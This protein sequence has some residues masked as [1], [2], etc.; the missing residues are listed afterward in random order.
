MMKSNSIHRYAAALLIIGLASF[1]PPEIHAQDNSAVSEKLVLSEQIKQA[2]KSL[3]SAS[4][5]KD[6]VKV[7][8]ELSQLRSKSD[9]TKKQH[10]MDELALYFKEVSET[11]Q[12]PYVKA[13][14]LR[15]AGVVM[16]YIFRYPESRQYFEQAYEKHPVRTLEERTRKG[17]LYYE[18]VEDDWYA[19]RWEKGLQGFVDFAGLYA[20]VNVHNQQLYAFF[21][22]IPTLVTEVLE[23]ESV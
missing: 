23:D 16:R 4:N 13:E 10:N 18:I 8:D 2:G 5:V 12:E 1:L 9:H 20:E 7:L 15:Q 3:L 19:G 22:A 21:E 14:A 11:E 17:K 6:K